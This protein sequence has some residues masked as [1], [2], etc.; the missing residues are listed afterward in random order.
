MTE[1]TSTPAATSDSQSR[2]SGDRQGS[3]NSGGTMSVVSRTTGKQKK[4]KE[5]ISDRKKIKVLK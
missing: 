2:T 3:G 5:E 1:A 4:S